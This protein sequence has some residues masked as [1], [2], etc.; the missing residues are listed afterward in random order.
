MIGKTVFY[1]WLLCAFASV[2]AADGRPWRP[3]FGIDRVG[4]QVDGPDLEADAEARPDHL[5]NPVDLG[6]IL[7]PKDWL[8]LAGGQAAL[9]DIAALSRRRDI[10]DGRVRVWF[11]GG[12][13]VEAAIQL[14][15]NKRVSKTLELPV[16]LAV[17]TT[18]LHVS[19]VEHGRDLWNKDIRTMVVTK[20]NSWPAFG[21]VE[22]KLR[23]DARIS[24]KE[25]GGDFSSIAFN[26]GWDSKFNDIVVFLPNGSRFVF[27]RGSSYAPFW[28]G[29]HNTG[30]S[31]QWAE[32]IPPPGYLDAVEPLQDKELRYSRV[33][34]VESTSSRVH[35][36]WMY[37]SV[38][39]NYRSLGDRATEDFFFYPDG[40]GTRV[41]T[42][43]SS[44]P[45]DYVF[46]EF[47]VLLPQSAFPLDVLPHPA[48]DLLFINGEKK[49]VD[50]PLKV[51]SYGPMRLPF[52]VEVKET[53]YHPV[54]RLVAQFMR[55]QQQQG[56]HISAAD[57]DSMNQRFPKITY[58]SMPL[59]YRISDHKDDPAT[60][61]YFS[62]HASGSLLAFAP[63]K[64]HGELV[65]PAYWG[66]HWPLAR[67]SMTGGAISDRIYASPSHLALM[68]LT[69]PEALSIEKRH[70]IDALG[71]S[72]EMIL[73]TRAWLIAKTPLSD[74]ELVKWAKSFSAA[75]SLKVEG[76]RLDLPSYSQERRAIRLVAEAAS[77][78][79]DLK[80]LE[81]LVNPVFE[82]ANV[83]SDLSR[84]TVDGRALA[85][86]EYAW[87]G[88]TLWIKKTI[89]SLGTRVDLEFSGPS[90]AIVRGSPGS[91]P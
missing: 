6:T 38:D 75:P 33:N 4:S 12:A 36:R 68:D 62:A 77:I 22:T 51:G 81:H 82:L 14:E 19:I 65:T 25:P 74:A 76:A 18:V 64:D 60:P 8:L 83:R 43:A 72:R 88:A 16:T 54:E 9:I 35:V 78:H 69:E 79:I 49:R 86:D 32:T 10:P 53:E 63:F 45:Q 73:Q 42:I 87:D 89:D 30:F 27:W 80:P 21:A 56:K 7:V 90:S 13:P 34:V 71:N 24:L 37:Q 5:I 66:D 52:P 23:Y 26:Q 2:A 59:V 91:T 20:Q 85:A 1:M 15:R 31:Y 17:D 48:V 67:G 41:V 58:S 47:I 70:L 55:Y 50:F 46:S 40:F 44:R 61:I 3:P 57:V 39:T 11:D 29:L 84:I 28:A